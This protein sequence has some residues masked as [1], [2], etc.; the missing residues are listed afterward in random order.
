MF[1]D[2]NPLIDS[3]VDALLCIKRCFDAGYAF[4]GVRRG[5]ECYCGA[6]DAE[7]YQQG[8]V[9]ENLCRN[10]CDGD[11][12]LLCG[13]DDAIGVFNGKPGNQTALN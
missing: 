10:P 6:D 3:T 7:Y 4:A 1:P 9:Y 8:A 12:D 11:E 13:G 2:G 5:N